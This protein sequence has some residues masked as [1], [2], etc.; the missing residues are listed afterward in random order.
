MQY[1]V[2]TY[3]H[4]SKWHIDL[5]TDTFSNNPWPYLKR[6]KCICVYESIFCCGWTDWLGDA[7]S[8]TGYS[9]TP[10]IVVTANNND[11]NDNDVNG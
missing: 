9:A 10:F 1:N 2:P 7:Q 6:S 4:T 11:N 3:T 8:A 5:N